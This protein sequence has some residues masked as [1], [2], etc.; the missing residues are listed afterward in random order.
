MVGPI[1]A[2]HGKIEIAIAPKEIS[3]ALG[4]VSRRLHAKEEQIRSRICWHF[5]L[6]ATEGNADTRQLGDGPY[7]VLA[8]LLNARM[9]KPL[10]SIPQ[11]TPPLILPMGVYFNGR[12]SRSC[13]LKLWCKCSYP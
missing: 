2:S 6:L 4:K 10:Q 9:E 11:I 8:D 5:K 3:S 13:P 1:T 12:P 7:G